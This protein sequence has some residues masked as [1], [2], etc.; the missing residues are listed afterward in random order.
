MATNPGLH[1][2][3]RL[4]GVCLG[5]ILVVGAL[6]GSPRAASAG[7]LETTAE[8]AGQLLP[9]PPEAVP[10]PLPDPVP[11][12]PDA[13]PSITAPTVPDPPVKLPTPVPE[14]PVKVPSAPPPP[15]KVPTAPPA[16]VPAVPRGSVKVPSVPPSAAPTP[17]APH[18][19]A[20]TSIPADAGL[21]GSPTSTDAISSPKQKRLPRPTA[22]R[23]PSR[24]GQA[25]SVEPAQIAPLRRYFIHVWDAIALG[26]FGAVLDQRWIASLTEMLT[27]AGSTV[28]AWAK[29]E[30]PDN[31]SSGK[32]SIGA[33]AQSSKDTESSLPG[34][35]RVIEPSS[36]TEWGLWILI[37]GLTALLILG[38]STDLGSR[39]RRRPH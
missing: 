39:F 33:P 34:F 11:V 1:R 10:A 7:Q 14:A 29:P 9:P 31:G 4:G 30:F 28:A 16:G 6:A 35:L 26:P 27:Q 20:K 12:P 5:A 19:P 17:S 3:S 36:N 2:C 32:A 13:P 38:S 25:G 15:V 8:V 18:S 37:A 23:P 24:R 22:A 21:A